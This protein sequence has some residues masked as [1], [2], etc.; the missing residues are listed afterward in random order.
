MRGGPRPGA[1]RPR[2]RTAATRE[3]LAAGQTPLEYLLE[4]MRDESADPQRRDRAAVSA[5]PFCHIKLADVG[6]KAR[7]KDDA[8]TAGEDSDWGTDLDPQSWGKN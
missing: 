7:E 4:L 2:T 1:G 3:A 6:K 8:K 5:A